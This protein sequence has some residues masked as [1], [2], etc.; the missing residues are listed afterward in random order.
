MYSWHPETP[1]VKH[2][3]RLVTP[4]GL[5]FLN[6]LLF[7]LN[8]PLRD[9]FSQRPSAHATSARV[10]TFLHGSVLRACRFMHGTCHTSMAG[11]VTPVNLGQLSQL[12]G[13]TVCQILPSAFS[14]PFY[15]RLRFDP[16]GARRANG[17]S[18]LT[19]RHYFQ[20]PFNHLSSRDPPV[21]TERHHFHA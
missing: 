8:V 21:S 11:S 17:L 12:T 19:L 7:V 6:G 1:Q 10:W 14:K 2:I 15:L 20:S 5:S 18:T 9:R 16:T 13:V 3:L 4:S